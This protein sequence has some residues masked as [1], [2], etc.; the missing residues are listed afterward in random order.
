[1]RESQGMGLHTAMHAVTSLPELL[2]PAHAALAEHLPSSIALAGCTS[3]R[4]VAV[5]GMWV[6]GAGRGSAD[7]RSAAA[8]YSGGRRLASR[9]ALRTRLI[10]LL[11]LAS[12][13]Y[14][15]ERSAMTSSAGVSASRA[16]AAR[17]MADM[18]GGT[19]LPYWPSNNLKH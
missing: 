19:S 17:S 12:V 1:M 3:C 15:C 6:C 5:N 9:T 14:V 2:P 18:I 13:R 11:M 10:A 4:G 8:S 7:A 16:V